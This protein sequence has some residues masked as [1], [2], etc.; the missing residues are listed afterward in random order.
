VAGT[1]RTREPALGGPA[2]VLVAPQLGENIGTAAR[3]MYNFGLTDLRLVRPRDGWPSEKARASASGADAVI[4]GAQVF[5]SVAEAIADLRHLYAATAR[6][7]D[8]RKAVVT[9]AHAAQTM[10]AASPQGTDCGILFGGERA[11]LDNDDVALAESIIAVPLNPAFSSLN[12]AQAVLL[13]SYEWFRSVDATARETFD[14]GPAGPATKADL[15]GLFENLESEL[16]RG[17]FLWP[18]EKAP[19]MVRNIRTMLQRARLTEQEVRTFRGII[20]AL[21]DL[22]RR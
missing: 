9:P 12:L 6:P 10:R 21:T 1:D 22:R 15:I 3:A 8:A 7:R 13:V 5:D 19:T 2:I 14:A 11:G 18:P 4:D 17:G 16:T 20:K